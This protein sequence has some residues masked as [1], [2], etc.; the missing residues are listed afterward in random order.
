[1]ILYSLQ[2]IQI[3]FTII[4]VTIFGFF[5]VKTK[6]I[7]EQD[8][9]GLNKILVNIIMPCLLF[10]Q[11]T[12][13]ASPENLKK[14]WFL[15]FV[16]LFLIL[17]GAFLGFLIGKFFDIKNKNCMVA[18]LAFNNV[19]YL[20]VA[21]IT[22]ILAMKHP[23]LGTES[24]FKEG[25]LA[26]SVFLLVFTP[27]MW[28]FGT[29]LI[30]G[31]TIK[32]ISL[33]KLIPPP[34]I[35]AVVSIFIGLC[36]I[37]RNLFISSSNSSLLDFIWQAAKLTGDATVP[38]ALIILGANLNRLF[39]LK[40]VSAKIITLF[41]IAKFII[42]PLISIFIIFSLEKM[43]FKLSPMIKFV[44]ILQGCIPPALNLTII[45]QMFNKNKEYMSELMF[46]AYFLSAPALAF[47]MT[48]GIKLIEQH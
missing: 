11:I 10:T 2:S 26:I 21:I 45:C 28:I 31:E 20:P 40:Y 4:L 15:L 6:I 13:A 33:I 18:A 47:W 35:T 44:I 23:I 41:S 46:W 27:L 43:G 9:N 12:E 37:T 32:K 17:C 42:L 36:P 30:S 5:L 48:F 38:C 25:I 24:A 29:Y 19:G 34:F 1:M 8:V 39:S 16:V 3:V 7:N 14:F 22:V